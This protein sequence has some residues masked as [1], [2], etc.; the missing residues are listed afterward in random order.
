MKTKKNVQDLAQN[1]QV[2]LIDGIITMM[3]EKKL[4]DE[5]IAS[6]LPF[7]KEL[8]QR[9]NFSVDAA[10]IFCAMFQ[11]FTD[12]HITIVDIANFYDCSQVKILT[13]W[14]AIEEL[15]SRRYIAQYKDNDGETHYAIPIEVIDAVR[16]NSVYTPEEYTNLDINKWVTEV[17][18][19]LYK[20]DHDYIPYNY[21][22]EE[23]KK[24]IHSNLHLVIARELATFKNDEE[25][26]LFMAIMDL[27]IL[28]N[29]DHVIREDIQDMLESRWQ[30]RTIMRQL[31]NGTHPLQKAGLVEYS[32][33][34]GQAEKDA[35]KLT[36]SAKAR[37][38]PEIETCSKTIE[39]KDIKAADTIMPKQLYYSP[40]VTKQIR[41]L[42]SLMNADRFATVQENLAQHGMRKGFA[43]I[44]YGAP[45]TGKT[46][47]VLQLARET[48]R[49]L[50]VVDVPNLRSKWVGETEKNAKAIFERYRNCCKQ[51]ALAPILLF[52]EADAILCKRNGGAVSAV[53]KMEN[54]MQNIILQEMENFEGILIATTNL[55]GN[56][57]AAFERRFLYKIEFP[58]PTPSESQ[59]IWHSMLPELTEQESLEL[60][61]LYS[62][63]GGQ[64]E[65]IA[66]KQIV[67]AV[68]TGE[69]KVNLEAI[70]EACKTE[71]FNNN[72]ERQKIGF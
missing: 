34:E 30:M 4:S 22:V 72:S 32:D 7:I 1:T 40:S 10:M 25:L 8:A 43:C 66:R 52:N 47:S 26:I 33:S 17:S 50:M 37:F 46:E 31:V 69:D 65:N 19:L 55:T 57:D 64:I 45:G 36:S 12:K 44:F 56:L 48:G 2:Q 11:R 39:Y 18:L 24:L 68:L 3:R 58:K 61:K 6:A 28:N 23:L 35:W 9:N 49:G 63:S 59:H 60:A 62:F 41:Q 14:S 27:Y 13:Y 16:K 70:H 67:N 54:A 29:D 5:N 42:A 38:L 15:I 20:K 71:L 21:M 53:D 51:T